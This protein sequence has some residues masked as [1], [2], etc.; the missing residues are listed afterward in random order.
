MQDITEHKRAEDAE[1]RERELAEALYETGKILNSSLDLETVLDRLLEA[2]ARVVPYDSGCVMLVHNGSASVVRMRGYEQYG[3]TSDLVTQI[4]FDIQTTAAF[5]EMGASHRPMLVSDTR[6]YSEWVVFP[7]SRH[8]LSWVGAP[9]VNRGQVIGFLSLDKIQAG[10]YQPEHAQNLDIF[11]AQAVLAIQNA[12]LFESA[13]QHAKEN[14]MLKDAAAAVTSAL[15]LEQVL[16]SILSQLERVVHYDS[17]TIFLTEGDYLRIVAVRGFPDPSRVIG[18]IFSI[19][20]VLVLEADRNQAP[21]MIEDASTDPRFNGWCGT[22]YTRGWLGLPLFVRGEMIGFLTLDSRQPHAYREAETNL[23][24]AFAHQASIAIDNA[25][26]FKQVHHLAITD[27]LTGIFNR[28]HFFELASVEFERASRY[29]QPLSLLM[30]DIDHFK[31]VN[32]THGHRIGD[33]VLRMVAER[34][35]Q[36][37]REGDLLGRYGGEEF[38]ALLNGAD[39]ESARIIGE[40]V[41]I[42]IEREPYLVEGGDVSISI[43]VGVADLDDCQSLEVML[44]RADQA[45]YQAKRS[46][47]NRVLV[48]STVVPLVKEVPI[49]S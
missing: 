24:W 46:G 34:G 15:E 25:R 22:R 5:R 23:A 9:M 26:L 16:E 30:W 20:D 19:N 41:R 12:Q 37:L 44:D 2:I 21:I 17:A 13:R 3:V 39:R 6:E 40:R 28:R 31:T 42:A 43:S 14:L 35:R 11:A 1:N 29:S 4:P 27:P 7:S 48:W 8:V 32:D 47:R 36:N 10:F 33:Q 18:T 38:V 45:L 49:E